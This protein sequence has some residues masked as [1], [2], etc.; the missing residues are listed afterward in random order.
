MKKA[1]DSWSSASFE[2]VRLT[3]AHERFLS[4]NLRPATRAGSSHKGAHEARKLEPELVAPVAAAHPAVIRSLTMGGKKD[5]GALAQRAHQLRDARAARTG[6]IPKRAATIYE[7]AREAVDAARLLREAGDMPKALRVALQVP[8]S[9][10]QY[11]AAARLVIAVCAT[12]RGVDQEVEDFL[13]PYLEATPESLLDQDAFFLLGQLYEVLDYSGMS[14]WLFQR[15]AK[16]NPL[17][18]VHVHLRLNQKPIDQATIETQAS[19]SDLNAV[20]QMLSGAGP[21]Q[22]ADSFEFGTVIAGRYILQNLIG[23]GASAA[24][25]DARDTLDGKQLALKISSFTS[26]DLLAT[27][28]FRREA[29]LATKL[30]HPNIVRVYDIGQ[31]RGHSFLA[32]ELVVGRPLDVA[33]SEGVDDPSVRGKCELLLQALAGLTCAHAHGVV[34]RDIKPENMLISKQ[35]VLKLTDFGLAKGQ[36]ED[37]I[38]ASGVMGGT[39]SYISPEQ[40]LDI[41][42]ADARSDLYSL[43]IVAYELFAGC[44]PFEASALTQLLVQHLNEEPSPLRSHAP[45]V[46]EPV[47][48]WVLRLLRKKPDER[49]GGS[50]EAAAALR[51]AIS[52]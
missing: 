49:F 37:R 9:A 18:P 22:S 26:K 46:P 42:R 5:D 14:Q 50:A 13:A 17:H 48:R 51:A 52:S 1:N 6:D 3:R 31:D 4:R 38:T 24:V 27:R 39:P 8:A 47:E 45:S 16:Q 33:I 20:R 43:G 35:G 7:S 29:T 23:C 11:A 12:R 34:H 25:Y 28:R 30:V 40:I 41:Y 2:A 36:G 21:R 15:L 32:M 44:C 19:N 10:P